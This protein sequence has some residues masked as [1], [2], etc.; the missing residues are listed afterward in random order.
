[1]LYCSALPQ[2][3]CTSTSLSR[4]AVE[5]QSFCLH[6][7]TRGGDDWAQEG[8]KSHGVGGHVRE[9]FVSVDET[10]QEGGA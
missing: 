2:M 9:L 10:Q 3:L 7:H 5:G 8:Q 4:R 1:M 6:G